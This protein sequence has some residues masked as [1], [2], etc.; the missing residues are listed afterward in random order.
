[1]T[2]VIDETK[3]KAESRTTGMQKLNN[4]LLPFIEISVRVIETHIILQKI[5]VA[6]DDLIP[7]CVLI[8][9]V[10]EKQKFPLLQVNTSKV[11]ANFIQFNKTFHH[12][13]FISSAKI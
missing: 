7:C 9:K 2:T 4:S 12:S 10:H 5:S 11:K 8:E 3:Y 6:V 1:M 13:H